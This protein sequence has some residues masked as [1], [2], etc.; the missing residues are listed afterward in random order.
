MPLGMRGNEDGFVV[1][2]CHTKSSCPDCGT[3]AGDGDCR[4]T[5]ETVIFTA[6]GNRIYAYKFVIKCS[7]GRRPV[8]K[9]IRD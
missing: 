1:S 5:Q 4:A 6:N 9:L 3:K 2:K 7:C 8:I